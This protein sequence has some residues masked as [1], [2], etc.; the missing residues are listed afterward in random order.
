MSVDLRLVDRIRQKFDAGTLPRR[1]PQKILRGYGVGDAC[2]ACGEP[3]RRAQG[4]CEFDVAEQTYR[5]HTSCYGL[6]E[7]EL[8]RRGLFK[9]Q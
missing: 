6:W 3:I 9:P 1:H 7:G 2:S 4:V 8:I 5:L